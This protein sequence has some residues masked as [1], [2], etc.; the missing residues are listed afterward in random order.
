M[1]KLINIYKEIFHIPRGIF[2]K[3][4]KNLKLDT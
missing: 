2:E 1:H 4:E 3:N